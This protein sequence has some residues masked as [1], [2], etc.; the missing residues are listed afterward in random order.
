MGGIKT[1]TWGE[2]A[3]AG[4]YAAGE[5]ACVSIHGANRLG[6]NSL[7]ETIVFGRR[8]GLRASEYVATARPPLGDA[9]ALQRGEA[10]VAR[11]LKNEGRERAWQGRGGVGKGLGLR[12]GLARPKGK[13]NA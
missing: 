8:A 6:G 1:N 9:G 5:C 3:L 13:I 10:R 4:L 2:T 7:L 11:P 12:L